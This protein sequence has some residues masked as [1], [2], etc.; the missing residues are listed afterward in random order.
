MKIKT[1]SRS[2]D[3]ARELKTDIFKVQ[4]NL[5]AT[6][7]PFEKQ[8]EYTRALNATKLDKLFAKPFVG[9]LNGHV[10]GI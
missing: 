6:L 1:I 3:F 7:H 2:D 9:Q 8:R 10:D 4:K 5:D